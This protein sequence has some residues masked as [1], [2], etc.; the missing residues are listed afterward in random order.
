MARLPL[1]IICALF[2]AGEAA[3][4]AYGQTGRSCPYH[5]GIPTPT[6]CGTSSNPTPIPSAAMGGNRIVQL[7]CNKVLTGAIASLYSYDDAACH[8]A[9]SRLSSIGAHDLIFVQNAVDALPPNYKINIS[10]RTNFK[11][12]LYCD[13]QVN[14]LILAFRGSIS[15]TPFDR[16]AIDDWI[17][18]NVVQQLGDRPPQYQAAEDVALSSQERLEPRR[19]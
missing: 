17:D 12:T 19:L 9:R 2:L 4:Q 7:G 13:V 18:T 11:A 8:Q 14:A 5:N 15:L 16:N 6:S 1:A 3:R 10:Q